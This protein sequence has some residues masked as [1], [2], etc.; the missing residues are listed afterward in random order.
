M[1]SSHLDQKSGTAH[2]YFQRE[3]SGL[4]H[5]SVPNSLTDWPY[6]TYSQDPEGDVGYLGLWETDM[7]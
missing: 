1:L 6:A 2:L 3:I 5:K 4:T 7:Q